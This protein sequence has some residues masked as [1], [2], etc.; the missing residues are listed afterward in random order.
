MCLNVPEVCRVSYLE[1]FCVT[2]IRE[3]VLGKNFNG[4]AT[5]PFGCRRVKLLFFRDF[6]CSTVL[7]FE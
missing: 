2:Q 1:T 3:K 6:E 4:V 7:V 5:N